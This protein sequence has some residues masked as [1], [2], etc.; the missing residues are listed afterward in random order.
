MNIL[1]TNDDGIDCEGLLLLAEALREIPGYTVFVFAPDG[2]RSGVS[3]S[4]TLNGGAL[5]I[6]DRGNNVWSCSGT[7]ADC[8]MVAAMGGLAPGGLLK[9]DMV[10]SGINAG[11]NLGTDLVYSGTAAAARQAALHGIPAIALSL[12][13]EEGP[14]YW[15]RAVAFARDHLEELLSLWKEDT[16]INVNIPNSP[17]FSGAL[18]ITFPCRRRYGDAIVGFDA[19]DGSRYCFIDGGPVIN[20]AEP[21]S[22]G[23]AVSRN[24]VSVSPVFIHPVVCGD[25]RAA[26][27]EPRGKG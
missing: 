18:E 15:D 1:L 8:A 21:G 27:P 10:V 11:A 13:I 6:R 17:D 9:P 26:W 25:I 16:F 12:V 4:I 2:E 23:D 19:P 7:P 22:D 5:R 3:Q 20:D 14:A 24:R